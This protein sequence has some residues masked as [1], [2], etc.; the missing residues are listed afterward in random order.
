MEVEI[1]NA[2]RELRH[3]RSHTTRTGAEVCR[4][5]P[6]G[7]RSK[8]WHGLGSGQRILRGC[9]VWPLAHCNMAVKPY[10]AG[11]PQD[12]EGTRGLGNKI[13]S[14]VCGTN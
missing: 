8:I 12:D 10:Q 11:D 2:K 5:E 6:N 1:V 4:N 9:E 13:T 14:K 7:N 3:E